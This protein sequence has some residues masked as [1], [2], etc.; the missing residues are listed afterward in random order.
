MAIEQGGFCPQRKHL[1]KS[2][3]IFV[4]I[5]VG[6]FCR[7]GTIHIQQLE[8][9]DTAKNP[10]VYGTAPSSPAQKN[11]LAQN[12]SSALVEKTC[13]KRWQARQYFPVKSYTDWSCGLVRVQMNEDLLS[14]QQLSQNS[15][16]LITSNKGASNKIHSAE[17]RNVTSIKD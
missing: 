8:T 15:P 7:V 13:H 2:G 16:F 17:Q 14:T 1:P 10:T 4:V 9:R 11:Y 5:P 3:K 6:G 12:D